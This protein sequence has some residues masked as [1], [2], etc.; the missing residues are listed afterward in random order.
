MALLHAAVGLRPDVPA[1]TVAVS[2]L[3]GAPLGALSVRGLRV[4]GHPVDV[5]VS[6]VAADALGA[7]RIGAEAFQAAS[8]TR[9]V[10]VLVD[11]TAIVA[12][13]DALWDDYRIPAEHGA[14]TAYAALSA[15]AYVPGDGERVAVIV[16]G[17]NTDPSTLGSSTAAAPV[18]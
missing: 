5:T 6:G 14:A 12:A 8:A 13:R 9:P 15:G 11:D 3:G 7:R 1:G 10:N 18:P 4:A 2:P 16:C 17:A